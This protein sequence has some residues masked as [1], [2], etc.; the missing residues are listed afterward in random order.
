MLLKYFDGTNIFNLLVTC[1]SCEYRA[2]S[3]TA[4]PLYAAWHLERAAI[5]HGAGSIPAAVNAGSLPPVKARRRQNTI[6][7][8]ERCKQSGKPIRSA[9]RWQ[10]ATGLR[11]PEKVCSHSEVRNQTSTANRGAGINTAE[12]RRTVRYTNDARQ[13]CADNTGNQKNV[14]DLLS[15]TGEVGTAYTDRA[16]TRFPQAQRG[17]GGYKPTQIV[18]AFCF[19]VY[20]CLLFEVS[21][22][23]DR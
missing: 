18:W 2:T 10:P 1:T 11:E 5:W 8:P 16:G 23:G 7:Q 15:A 14:A 19:A 22:D 13:P 21:A 4:A 12:H 20:S 3:A 6:N 17:F 9:A